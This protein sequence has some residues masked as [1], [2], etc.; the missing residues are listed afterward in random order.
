MSYLGFEAF[1]IIIRFLVLWSIWIL[2]LF[3]FKNRP[4][5]LTRGTAIIIIIVIIIIIL[6]IWEFFTP[7]LADGFPLESEWL[8]ASSGLQ[9]SS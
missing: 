1:G 4:E 5:Y 6:L 7:T 9:D 8:L 2:P 3:H